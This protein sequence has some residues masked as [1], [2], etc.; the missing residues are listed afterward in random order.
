M[1]MKNILMVL[2][3]VAGLMTA[4]YRF[5]P[6]DL[7]SKVDVHVNNLAQN[8]HL[9]STAKADSE[10]KKYQLVIPDG[11]PTPQKT[12]ALVVASAYIQHLEDVHVEGQ[13]RLV[14]V[15]PDDN[16]GSKHQRFILKTPEDVTIL[17]AHNIDIAKRVTN[18]TIGDTIYFSGEYVWNEK[19][20]I[21]HWTHQDPRGN[22]VSGWL[23]HNGVTYQ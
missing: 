10:S 13:G 20:G 22:H 16:D 5:L 11:K 6:A 12:E 8:K 1:I 7:R 14:K 4:T 15:L 9:L 3:V 2:V 21:V 19:G 17:I 18:L 23:K